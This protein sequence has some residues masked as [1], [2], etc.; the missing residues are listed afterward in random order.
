MNRTRMVAIGT[1]TGVIV[2]L[3][4]VIVWV[5]SVNASHTVLVYRV[6][7]S[8]VSAGQAY[9]PDTVEQVSVKGETGEFSYTTKTPGSSWVFGQQLHAGD[10]VRDDDLVSSADVAQIPITPAESV[11]FSATGK[12]DIYLIDQ[13][14]TPQC[15]T[16]TAT[17]VP[18][19]ANTAGT[20]TIQVPRSQEANWLAIT[21][22]GSGQYRILV[23]PSGG[24][25][26]QPSSSCLDNALTQRLT[27]IAAATPTP[28][29]L[30]SG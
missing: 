11:D 24:T 6:K 28:I 7:A 21:V 14:Q 12:I 26:Q 9:S 23:A 29:P 19:V 25:A 5:E 4:V 18:V 2:L 16:L 20:L 27:A 3:I 1:F 13:N 30:P 8:V 22:A 15:V 10:I 17:Q